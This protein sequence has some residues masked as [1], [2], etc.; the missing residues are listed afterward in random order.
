LPAVCNN[1]KVKIKV[2]ESKNYFNIKVINII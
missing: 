1:I 2:L